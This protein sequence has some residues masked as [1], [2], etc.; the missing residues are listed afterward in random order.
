MFA[1]RGYATTTMAQIAT[2]AGAGLDTVYA[3]V[4]RK[5][6]LFR[7]LIE[8]ALSGTDEPIAPVTIVGQ[9]ST[10]A[11]LAGRRSW[12]L[13]TLWFDRRL[14]GEPPVA[15]TRRRSTSA[16]RGMQKGP[17]VLRLPAPV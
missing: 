14:R 4:G 16:A 1:E 7:L 15:V 5:P 10:A 9:V 2:T 17:E 12:L 6:T 3:A 13:S 11:Q 8:S